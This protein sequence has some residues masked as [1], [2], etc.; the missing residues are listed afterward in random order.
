MFDCHGRGCFLATHQATYYDPRE[1]PSVPAQ[2]VDAISV[3]R[4]TMSSGRTAPSGRA[5]LIS[6]VV[7]DMKSFSM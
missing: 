6:S 5:F 2:I 1:P 7:G 3:A 4:I